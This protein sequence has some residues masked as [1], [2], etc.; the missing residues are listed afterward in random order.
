[1]ACKAAPRSLLHTQITETGQGSTADT[2][3][4]ARLLVKVRALER[5]RCGNVLLGCCLRRA[6]LG[7]RLVHL[8]ALTRSGA[9]GTRWIDELDI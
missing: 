3:H 8:G 4:A 7:A 6:R 2:Q 1:M 5:Q 9:H